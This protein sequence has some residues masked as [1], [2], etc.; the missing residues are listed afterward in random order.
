M[1]LNPWKS[2]KQLCEIIIVETNSF[3]MI[4][5]VECALGLEREFDRYLADRML[6]LDAANMHSITGTISR[7]LSNARNDFRAQSQN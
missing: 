6:A 4:N 3:G 7:L 5:N 2:R 1:K